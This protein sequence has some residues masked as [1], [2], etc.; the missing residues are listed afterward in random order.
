MARGLSAHLLGSVIS[1]GSSLSQKTHFN[2]VRPVWPGVGTILL[3]QCKQR[4]T[5]SIV[6]SYRF[7]LNE[8]QEPKFHRGVAYL[9]AS[10][11]SFTNA[12]ADRSRNKNLR[13]D[14]RFHAEA[15]AQRPIKISRNL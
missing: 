14:G 11:R 4:V 3:P 10:P 15:G 7:G 5:R 6:P 8:H 9:T 12:G 13:D 2:S 1:I